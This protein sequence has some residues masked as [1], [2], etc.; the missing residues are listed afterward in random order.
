LVDAAVHLF[1]QRMKIVTSE[2]MRALDRKAIEGHGIPSLVL[3]ERAGEGLARLVRPFV[4]EDGNVLVVAGR[5]NNGGDGLVAARLLAG[6]GIQVQTVMLDAE[7]DLSAD[8]RINLQKL[9]SSSVSIK[10]VA[11]EAELEA[12]R[13]VFLGASVIVDALFGT[14]LARAVGG[15]PKMIIELMNASDAHVISADIPSGLSSDD[16]SVQ[17]LAVRAAATATFGLPKCGLFVGRGPEYAGRVEV[18]DIGIPAAEIAKIVSAL[19]LTE[20][21]DFAGTLRERKLLSHKGS[22]GHVVV[23]AGARGHLG[24]GYLTSLAALRAGCGLVT[25]CLPAA[26]FEKFDARYPEIMCE[27]IPDGGKAAFIDAGLES[28]LQILEGKSAFAIGPAVGQDAGTRAFTNHLLSRA[29]LPAVIDADGLNV[30]DLD[31][32]KERNAATILTPHPGEMARLMGRTVNEIESDRV[33]IALA[34]AART[35]A[36]VVLK[37]YRTVIADPDGRAFINPTGNPGMASAGMGDTLTGF[38][39]SLLAQGRPPLE[40]A[41][42]S[43]YVHGLAGDIAAREIGDFALIASDVAARFG[44]AL[45]ECRATI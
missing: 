13:H 24:A 18:M 44:R 17:G 4:R 8:A 5:G 28:A 10:Q 32:I 40:A 21:S 34:C 9:G 31:A 27:A 7:N 36:I 19:N 39:A 35:G 20:P 29:R 42:A 41:Q 22:Y 43:V 1:P 38:I 33:G 3:M 23:F 25:Y 30:L 16:G 12:L 14:G 26:A 11:D 2:Q 6:S 15:L 37:G 45:E